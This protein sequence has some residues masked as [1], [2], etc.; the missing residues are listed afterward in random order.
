[1]NPHKRIL[2]AEADAPGGSASSGTPVAPADV[3]P[4]EPQASAAPAP[5]VDVN[6][7]VRQ[8][9]DAQFAELRR[10]GVIGGKQPKTKA[11]DAPAQPGQQAS[12]PQLDPIKLRA[13]DRSLNRNGIAADLTPSQYERA[14][15]AF[16]A[17]APDDVDSWVKDYFH[18]WKGAPPAAASAAA[19]AAP[20]AT[21]AAPKPQ[22]A[23]PVT[24]RGAPPPSQVP[25]EEADLV[26]MSDSDRNALIKQKGVSW[27]VQQL[28]KQMKGRPISIR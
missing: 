9:L 18:G 21:P 12:A 7:I 10:S 3:T 24:D 20:A 8:A 26:T 15:R 17:E 28:H 2:M 27:Y 4:T 22:T 23:H 5:T 6:A 11:D 25:L 14:E 13:L 19:P 16:A 1:M